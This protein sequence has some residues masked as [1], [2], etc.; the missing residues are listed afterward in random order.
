MRST[1]SYSSQLSDLNT[2]NRR[3]YMYVA[4]MTNILCVNNLY[5]PILLRIIKRNN[6]QLRNDSLSFIQHTVVLKQIHVV[7]D[8]LET[9]NGNYLDNTAVWLP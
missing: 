7:Y 4:T 1:P 2:S 9:D 3:I 8:H 5:C 6:C